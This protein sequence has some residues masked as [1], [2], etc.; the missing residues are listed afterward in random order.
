M[1]VEMGARLFNKV[2][3]GSLSSGSQAAAWERPAD[4]GISSERVEERGNSESV[5]GDAVDQSSPAAVSDWLDKAA[6]VV[7]HGVADQQP[8]RTLDSVISLL[9]ST[10]TAGTYTR[11]ET[12]PLTLRVP[13]LRVPQPPSGDPNVD[14]TLEI[15]RTSRGEVAAYDTTAIALHRAGQ[16][17]LDGTLVPPATVHFHEMYWADLSR[18]SGSV[19]RLVSEVF[20]IIFRLSRLARET[21]DNAA[22]SSPRHDLQLR[23]RWREWLSRDQKP[24]APGTPAAPASIV[25]PETPRPPPS[26]SPAS[27][28]IPGFEARRVPWHWHALWKLQPVMD[29]ALVHVLAMLFLTLSLVGLV[30]V[31]L[32]LA[33]TLDVNDAVH[34]PAYALGL[35]AFLLEL[36]ATFVWLRPKVRPKAIGLAVTGAAFAAATLALQVESIRELHLSQWIVFALLI[37]I[38]VC[39]HCAVLLAARKR[40][41]FSVAWASVWSATAAI[42]VCVDAIIA[43]REL[44]GAAL[45]AMATNDF[46]LWVTSTLFGVELVLMATKYAWIALGGL[47]LVWFGASVLACCV[48]ADYRQRGAIATGR[49][50]L[51]MSMLSFLIVSMLLWAG[52]SKALAKATAGVSYWP[53]IFVPDTSHGQTAL[54]AAVFLD[55]RFK[56]ST[57]AFAPAAVLL[58]VLLIYLLIM[59]VPS[60][61]SELGLKLGRNDDGKP[62][63]AYQLGRWLTR[64][65]AAFDAMVGWVI[66]AAVVLALVVAAAFLNLV[67]VGQTAGQWSQSLLAPFVMTAASVGGVLVAFG[68]VLSKHLPAVRA[69][70]DAILDVDNYFRTFP[71][72]DVPRANMMARFSALLNHLEKEGYKSIV[73]VAHSQ[74]TVL[75]ADLLR[76]RTW[77]G[78]RRN[79]P[80]QKAVVA[81]HFATFGS[82]LRQ[83]Y[84][85]RFPRWYE[86]VLHRPSFDAKTK[87][88]E[89]GGPRLEKTGFRRW[90]NGYCSGDYV[91]RWLW[92]AQPLQKDRKGR[93]LDMRGIIGNPWSDGPP[94]LVDGIQALKPYASYCFEDLDAMQLVRRA[95]RLECC[96]G[97]GAHTKYFEV[98]QVGTAWLIDHAV[99]GA[100][101]KGPV[102]AAQSPPLP[103]K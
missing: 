96:L 83:L 43:Y 49:L 90:V 67:D 86:W 25:Q 3:E 29:G 44:D 95:Q 20:T 1:T 101:W 79:A 58:G 39:L 64:C 10:S 87:A 92:S 42:A 47:I 45:R 35:I 59:F 53:R 54:D 48:A 5:A 100:L 18:L 61:L 11:G 15:L 14:K 56:A 73:I 69:P 66:A 4:P 65:I 34:V 93:A 23:R 99:L 38:A 80:Q 57:E 30:I 28:P 40:F 94:S 82:P 19:P 26:Q 16:T 36:A 97:Y 8:G 46:S 62:G 88:H 41:R 24:S 55:A 32:G 21:I 98:G 81:Y 52:I 50:G 22:T 51:G 6:V 74:G 103:P 37:L 91:G 76:L 12:T 85:A 63:G 31:G 75:A 68:G 9:V 102:T 7:V 84:A 2:G 17:L 33:R 78:R 13:P 60:V 89:V 71:V 77:Q 70:L 27:P 72:H